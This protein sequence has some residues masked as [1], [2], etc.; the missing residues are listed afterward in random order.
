MPCEGC[1]E[2]QALPSGKVLVMLC[3]QTR[4]GCGARFIPKWAK[5][6]GAQTFVWEAG[7]KIMTE[8]TGKADVRHC[9]CCPLCGF[10]PLKFRN[11]FSNVFRLKY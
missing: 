11:V 4:R 1:L 3:A 5:A 8:W 9:F 10:L 7:E 6:V 2:E